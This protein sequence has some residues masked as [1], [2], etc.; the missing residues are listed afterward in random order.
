[1]IFANKQKKI[2]SCVGGAT[3]RSPASLLFQSIAQ[4]LER[5]P[6]RRAVTSVALHRCSS[7]D[8]CLR[9]SGCF[10]RMIY[11]ISYRC[12]LQ[13]CPGVCSQFPRDSSWHPGYCGQRNVSC[14]AELWICTLSR[15]N[16]NA[17]LL[18]WIV[19]RGG[20]DSTC[21]CSLLGRSGVHI[22]TRTPSTLRFYSVI[23]RCNS[24]CTN[25]PIIEAQRQD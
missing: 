5:D 19:R 20:V 16:D 6:S 11:G 17:L 22:S 2:V 8:S 18:T 10:S 12:D 7:D 9:K 21:T 1:M 4:I 13:S 3:Q 23:S 25:I 14:H 15:V 24:W